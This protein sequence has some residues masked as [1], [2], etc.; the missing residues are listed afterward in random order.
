MLSSC[1]KLQ[2]ILTSHA[3]SNAEAVGLTSVWHGVL[4]MYVLCIKSTENLYSGL[5][6]INKRS[7]HSDALLLPPCS[8][9]YKIQL[10][11]RAPMIKF[12][13]HKKW[14][15]FQILVA[16]TSP[17]VT[18]DCRWPWMIIFFQGLIAEIP[19]IAVVD[20][21]YFVRHFESL[22]VCLL[23]FLSSS[24]YRQQC[25]FRLHKFSGIARAIPNLVFRNLYLYALIY[26]QPFLT[27]V[28]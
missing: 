12:T 27:C 23:S 8:K 13:W 6:G 11:Y 9:R 2:P 25:L 22:P 17:V 26:V 5:T 3:H 18:N 14:H 19:N 10:H 7:F 28:P 1:Y 4:H 24:R 15:N 16:R 20:A 21:L